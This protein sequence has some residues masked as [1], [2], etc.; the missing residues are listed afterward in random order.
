MKKVKLYGETI[1]CPEGMPLLELAKKYQDRE[2]HDIVLAMRNNKLCELH[3]TIEEDCTLRFITCQEKVGIQAYKRSI[4]LLALKA[5]YDVLGKEHIDHIIVDFSH[6]KGYYCKFTGE[7]ALTQA[8]IDRI[9]ERM[10]QLVSMDLPIEKRTMDREKALKLFGKYHMYDKER[11]FRYRRV[12]KVNIY[13][14][15]KFEDYYYG[16]MVPSTGYLKYFK[17]YLYAEGFVIQMPTE[18]SPTEVLPFRPQE[19]IFKVMEQTARWNQLLNVETVGDLNQQIS[20][21]K[22]KDII[23]VSEALQESRIARL[24]EKIAQSGKKIIL[25]A[26]PSSSGKTT[27]SHRLS[28]QLRVNGLK[29]HPIPVDDYFL[30]REETPRGADGKPNYEVLEAIDVAKFNQDMTDLLAG[31]CVELPTFNFKTG[32]R[33]YKGKVMELGAEDILVIEGIHCLNDKLTYGLPKESKFRIYISALTQLNLDEHN[34]ISTTD[35]RLLRRMVR[36]AR[37]RGTSARDTIAMWPKVREGEE[38]YIFP[39]QES[40]D[41]MFNSNLVYEVSVLKQYVEPLL[42]GIP[43]DCPEY[44]EARRLLKFLDYFLGVGSEDIPKNSLL[45]EFVGGSTFQI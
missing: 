24:A 14:L 28:I 3:K 37:T 9:E 27:F 34:R 21:G 26:G 6:G 2:T 45:R 38:A 5:C 13:S 44:L 12:S 23:L 18:Q 32:K 35:C 11:L 25:I 16:D 31:K 40:A 4:T 43:E 20:G 7:P 22:I 41:E 42:F 8:D 17:L 30:N 19:K 29:P 36:D 10:Q 39:H 15:G 33:E 1:T